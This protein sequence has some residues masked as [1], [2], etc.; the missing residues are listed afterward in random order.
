E[1]AA[2]GEV[3]ELADVLEVIYALAALSGLDAAQLEKLRA[4]KA[5]ERG[6]FTRRYVWHGNEPAGV[7]P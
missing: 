4:A 3:E 2:S 1:F 7:T 6:G 5:D